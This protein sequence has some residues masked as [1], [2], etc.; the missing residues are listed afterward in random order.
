MKLEI[1]SGNR[2][3][4]GYL[5]MDVRPLHGVDVVGDAR[6]LP[7]GDNHFGEIYSHWVFEHFRMDELDNVLQEWRRALM[8]GGRLCIVTSN[9]D[10]INTSL[11][12][13]EITWE[14]WVR[15]TFGLPTDP[16]EPEWNKFE[17][18]RV[19]DC[20]KSAFT[21]GFMQELLT[22]NGFRGIKVEAT[23]GCKKDGKIGCPG[24]IAEAMK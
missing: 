5:H 8:T 24:I 9:Q 4:P 22:R 10:S 7:F 12:N 13:K 18:F 21:V 19:E 15:L 1:G 11:A 6:R 16:D 14:E 17:D 2:P 3:T 23:W 20:H